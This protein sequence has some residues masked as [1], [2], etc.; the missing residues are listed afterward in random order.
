MRPERWGGGLP[1]VAAFWGQ[2][3][4]TLQSDPNVTSLRILK[5]VAADHSDHAGDFDTQSGLVAVR[6][7]AG[8]GVVDASGESG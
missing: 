3:K 5:P 7:I 4:I 1:F 2:L 6:G 8:W